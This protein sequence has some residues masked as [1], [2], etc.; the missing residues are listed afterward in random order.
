MRICI[1]TGNAHKVSEIEAAFSGTPGS[2]WP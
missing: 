1:A 2:S